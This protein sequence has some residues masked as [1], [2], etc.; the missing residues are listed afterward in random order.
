[1]VQDNRHCSRIGKGG[2]EIQCLKKSSRT[3]AGLYTHP[4]LDQ[5]SIFLGAAFAARSSSSTVKNRKSNMGQ[6]SHPSHRRGGEYPIEHHIT[7]PAHENETCSRCLS[8]SWIHFPGNA[9]ASLPIYPG[10]RQTS[11]S[12]SQH[13]SSPKEGSLQGGSG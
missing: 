2:I 3:Q 6:C 1:M 12:R 13:V 4:Q 9:A 10:L 11:S 5:S 7:P 8:S